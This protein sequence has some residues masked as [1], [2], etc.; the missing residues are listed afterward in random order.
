MRVQK[1]VDMLAQLPPDEEVGF[2]WERLSDVL[3]DS[4]IP[5]WLEPTGD[6]PSK[7]EDGDWYV[8]LRV[9]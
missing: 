4:Y 5:E 1:L 2:K 7:D 9:W 3:E 6:D 8:E